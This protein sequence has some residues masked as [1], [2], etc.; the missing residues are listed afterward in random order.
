MFVPMSSRRLTRALSALCLAAAAVLV[1]APGFAQERRVAA[2][3]FDEF[4][5]KSLKEARP[6]V[7]R[8]ADELKKR[9]GARGY[10]IGYAAQVSYDPQY[11]GGKAAAAQVRFLMTH[12][13]NNEPFPLVIVDGG[14][15]LEETVELFVV[16]VGAR[17]PVPTPTYPVSAAIGCARL[18]VEGPRHVWETSSP[19]TFS[20]KLGP[21]PRGVRPYF[22]WMVSPGRIISGQGTPRVS[23]EQ[24]AGDYRPI[25][26]FV[27][28]EGFPYECQM[29]EEA[30]SPPLMSVPHKFDEFGRIACGD[31]LA[32]L[33]NWFISLQ[34][35][36][37]LTA[38]VVVHDGS[39]ARP[40]EARARALRMKSY[41][42]YRRR[43]AF[44]RV[45][46]VVV[47][48]KDEKLRGEFW[49]VPRGATPPVDAETLRAGQVLARRLRRSPGDCQDAYDRI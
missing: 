5:Y 13:R 39:D 46:A 31:E 14:L 19:L 24:P 28:A 48:G 43:I 18:S 25:R 45:V 7:E 40:N 8:F 36:P 12:G 17:P 34:S 11:N 38:Y 30:Y 15:R 22:R 41:L 1:S 42:T 9:P 47:A 10:V 16:P 2:Y 32:R 23:V 37:R 33:D 44:E 26:A 35:D 3:K 4:A 49:L 21:L 20:A 27:V 29:W 6:R